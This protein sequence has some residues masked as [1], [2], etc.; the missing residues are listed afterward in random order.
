ME[1][2]DELLGRYTVTDNENGTKN[3]EGVPIFELGDFKSNKGKPYDDDWAERAIKTHNEIK[4]GDGYVP[5][6]FIGHTKDDE[7]KPASGHFDKL[8]KAGKKIIA[9]LVQI[10]STVYEEI[11]AGM[12]PSRSIE[13]VNTKSEARILG[14]ALLGSSTPAC[15][16][17]PVQFN[18]D[19]EDRETIKYV[20]SF[21]E[22]VATG[23][24]YQQLCRKIE[25]EIERELES[26]SNATLSTALNEKA[27][28]HCEAIYIN[29]PIAII[30][31]DGDTFSCTYTVGDDN[32]VGVT[33]LIEVEKQ[34]MPILQRQLEVARQAELTKTSK[35]DIEMAE[36]PKIEEEVIEEEV[37]EEVTKEVAPEDKASE[38]LLD[39]I[40]DNEKVKMAEKIA[41]LEAKQADMDATLK[42]SE[43]A[44]VEADVDSF[45][46]TRN[47]SGK[48]PLAVIQFDGDEK[49]TALRDL[50][51][52]SD[53]AVRD[54][55]KALLDSLPK[56]V[57]FTETAKAGDEDAKEEGDSPE[58]MEQ[59]LSDLAD[60][61]MEEHKDVS[62][63]EAQTAVINANADIKKYLET[64]LPLYKEAK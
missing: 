1:E 4:A 23:L 30:D 24:T 20:D 64:A 60:T 16:F 29:K 56:S 31:K 39:E 19:P 42:A 53:G 12:W 21:A 61:Y 62:L 44:A 51:L 37:I 48:L 34:Y 5:P 32:S 13:A 58:A 3:I 15:K 10:P 9:D 8:R 46:K 57:Q 17:G 40:K 50:L 45:I 7:E 47:V 41:E 36:E 59:K 43:K 11:K 26:V 28:V 25:E 52:A 35:E 49:G 54:G 22:A 55:L 33:N 18:G 63:K 14:L 6:V 38:K 2:F 27:Y